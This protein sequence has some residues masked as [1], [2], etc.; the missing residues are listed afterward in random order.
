MENNIL[1]EITRL[2][3][4]MDI[5]IVENQKINNNLITETRFKLNIPTPKNFDSLKSFAIKNGIDF[6]GIDFNTFKSL[7][8]LNLGSTSDALKHISDLKPVWIA[9]IMK[10]NKLDL[11]TA[12]KAY[13][14]T[15][16]LL[17]KMK[18]GQKP[19]LNKVLTSTGEP[20][21]KSLPEAGGMRDVVLKYYKQTDPAGFK[22]LL[23]NNASSAAAIKKGISD[24]DALKGSTTTKTTPTTPTTVSSKITSEVDPETGQKYDWEKVKEEFGSNGS[25]EDNTKLQQAW[26]KGWRPGKEVDTEFQTATYKFNNSESPDDIFKSDKWNDIKDIKLSEDQI[27]T[28]INRPWWDK[29]VTNFK[30]FFGKTESKMIELRKLTLALNNVEKGSEEYLRLVRL[31]EKELKS[32]FKTSFNSFIQMRNYLDNINDVEFQNVWN[33]IKAGSDD[34]WLTEFG[35]VTKYVTKMEQFKS[36]LENNFKLLED[37]EKFGLSLGISGIKKVGK[38]LSNPK[39]STGIQ[40]EKA[41]DGVWSNFTRAYFTG[42]KSGLPTMGNPRYKELIATKGLGAARIS[43]I[44]DLAWNKLKYAMIFSTLGYLRDLLADEFYADN[45]IECEE[46]NKVF[47]KELEKLKLRFESGVI[48]DEEYKKSVEDAKVLVDKGCAGVEGSFDSLMVKYSKNIRPDVDRREDGE[49]FLEKLYNNLIPKIDKEISWKTLDPGLVGETLDIFYS[50]RDASDKG[51]AIKER[52]KKINEVIDGLEKTYEKTKEK[53]EDKAD[54]VKD[55]TPK[56]ETPKMTPSQSVE[57]LNYWLENVGSNTTK[58]NNPDK[59]KTINITKTDNEQINVFYTSSNNIIYGYYFKEVG[60]PWELYMSESPISEKD[61]VKTKWADNSNWVKLNKKVMSESMILKTIK[62]MLREDKSRTKFGEDNFKHWKET[63]Q[64]K[65]EDEKN[66]GQY[67]DVKINMEDV[68]DR[69]DH[70]RKKYDEDDSFV[71]A[72]IDTHENIVKFM[73]TKDLAHIKESVKPVGLA[74]VLSY[75]TE[76]RG[77]MEIWSVARPANGNWFLVKGDFNK[78]QLSN[79]DLKKIE[80]KDKV[81]AKKEK[82]EEGLKKKEETAITRLRQDEK[83]GIE[84]LPRQVKQKVREKLRGGW[85]TEEPYEFLSDFY[86]ESEINSVFNDKIKI[87][88]LKA[89]KGFFEALKNNSSN[90]FIAKGFCKTLNSIKNDSDITDD[91]RPVVRHLMS[92]CEKKFG[93]DYG[94]IQNKRS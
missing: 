26:K 89:T 92:K 67:K 35:N 6:K 24:V 84:H 12:T 18:N 50:I 77:E 71:R 7:D 31:F 69:I 94:F 44:K 66:P 37:Y 25:L 1:E 40:L 33:S 9:K 4:L 59:I 20:A 11:N 75:I 53:I 86:A 58:W 74:Y 56:E 13:N 63:F 14:S 38:K 39:N 28:I 78:N 16:T 30:S 54:D 19:D 47:D 83:D 60:D 82:P 61:Q 42:S 91:T 22:K 27:K 15:K 76:S 52:M 70:Y 73:F 23:S 57:Y 64:F 29:V 8:D 88:K 90:I 79:M 49:V 43:Y 46:A 10:D 93:G 72:V 2:K 62:N 51:S 34:D 81:V 41:T 48:T 80:P 85:T 65:S 17:S 87:Y 3:N 21:W 36:G 55:K 5:G 68:M 32:T 45:R